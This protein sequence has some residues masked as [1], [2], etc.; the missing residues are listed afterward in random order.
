MKGQS[1][2]EA[3]IKIS[4]FFS[5]KRFSAD[6]VKKIKRLA[7]ARNLKLGILRK[8]FCKSCLSQLK[9]Q[10]RITKLKGIVYKT[11][12]CNKCGHKNRFKV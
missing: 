10:L 8:T 6:E 7:M 1:H 2:R 5:K 3:I 11:V 12:T 4:K 9:G